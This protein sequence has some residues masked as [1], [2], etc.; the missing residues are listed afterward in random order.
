MKQTEHSKLPNSMAQAITVDRIPAMNPRHTKAIALTA[1]C[2]TLF[3]TNFDGTA[4][5][6]ALPQIQNSLGANMTG[7]QW[8]IN[9][10]NLP[11]AS[12]LLASGTLGDI[13]GRRRLFLLGLAIFTIA[14]AL[15]GFAPNLQLLIAGRT[16]QGIGAAALIPLSLTILTATF[17][18]PQSK[19]KAIGIWSA[20]SALALVA[21]PGLGGLFVDR[22]GWQSIF[23]LN[24]PVG[25]ITFKL[26]A[27]VIQEPAQRTKQH[28]DLPGLGC[29]IM[30][31][32]SL[33][34]ALTQSSTST[35]LS[36]QMLALLG[37]TGLSLLGFWVAESRSRHPMLPLS[38]L[39]N[40]TF[41]LINITQALVFFTSGS[42][43]FMFSLFLQ[44]VQGYS[45]VEAG[46][47]FLPM[48][49]AIILAALGSGW[50]AARLG[51][52]FPVISGL[53]MAG[54][55]TLGLLH[56]NADTE[57][58]QVLWS[59][60]L[61]G[62]GGGLTIAPLTSAA[63][64]SVPALQEGIASAVFNISIQFGGILGIAIQGT[65]FAQQMAVALRR[66][67]TPWQLPAE[68]QDRIITQ[69]LHNLADLPS[70]LPETVSPLLLQQAIKA[71][72]VVGL[73]ATVLVAGLALLTGAL[74]ILVGAPSKFKR[75]S[76][77]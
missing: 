60:A 20:V 75:R 5:D 49:G 19:A 45:A 56:I 53:V 18:D 27:G 61:S 21:G 35:G 42:L 55:A 40:R 31:I 24:V 1:M 73:Q 28:L 62:F 51:W 71:A 43:L 22:L 10:Y 32:A 16:L 41:V 64:N 68:L 38:L 47:R 76:P 70:D 57:Y 14:S 23:L 12:L 58:G 66:S 39:R 4:V 26:T 74:L 50:V 17:P 59:L 65:L 33:T 6:V 44:Q 52:R 30:A 15:C 37:V 11:V 9:A 34:Y 54:V 67:L 7:L 63:M 46:I 48:N 29:S 2:L 69:A 77:T 13:Y 72:F 25:V 36:P 3:M 8:I